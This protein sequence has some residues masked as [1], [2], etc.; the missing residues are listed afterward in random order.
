MRRCKFPDLQ[1]YPNG[2]IPRTVATWSKKKAAQQAEEVSRGDGGKVQDT[3]QQGMGDRIRSRRESLGMTQERL[4]ELAGLPQSYVSLLESGAHL[5]TRQTIERLAAALK[6]T[7]CQLDP[8]C[9]SVVLRFV[10][11][12]RSCQSR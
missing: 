6:T 11:T 5:P 9:A 10:E 7:W 12:S 4:G 8:G 1:V 2:F 3:T